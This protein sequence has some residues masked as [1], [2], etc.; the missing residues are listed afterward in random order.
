M[1]NDF[2]DFCLWMYFVVDDIWLTIA[3]FFKRPGPAPDCPDSEL[4]AMALIGECR[5][6]D[7]ETEM[8]SYWQEHRDLF[9]KIPTQSR[10]NRRRRGLMQAFNMI[11]RVVLQ[12]LDVAQDHQCVIDRLPLPVMQFYLVPSSS[13]DWT[14]TE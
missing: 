13:G 10:F 5:G 1:I 12:S 6:W 11:R 7:V 3:P 8:L 9:P 2:N 14:A 4:L